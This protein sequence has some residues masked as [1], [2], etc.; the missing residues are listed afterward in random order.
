MNSIVVG[1][2]RDCVVPSI[3]FC[4]HRLVV[5]VTK[6]LKVKGIVL[7]LYRDYQRLVCFQSICFLLPRLVG[8]PHQ[9]AQGRIN[10][11]WHYK[12]RRL[13]CLL[14]PLAA[15]SSGRPHQAAAGNTDRRRPVYHG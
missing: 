1:L 2:F 7:G 14:L 10:R 4:C 13:F 11:C 8:R 6:L 3:C 9:H 12:Y 15:P 5:N